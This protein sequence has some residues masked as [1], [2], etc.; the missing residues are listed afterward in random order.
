MGN[1]MRITVI[2]GLLVAGLDPT[3]A[4]QAQ[5]AAVSGGW[6]AVS[7][8]PDGIAAA[9]SAV[10][11]NRFWLELQDSRLTVIRPIRNTAVR[12]EHVIGGAEVRSIVPGAPCLGD[13][14]IISSV[15]REGDAFVHTTVAMIAAGGEATTRS[16]VRHILRP[17]GG[18]RLVVESTMR[19]PGANAPTAVA[20]VYRRTTDTLPPA[21][22]RVGG[23][24]AG[25]AQVAWL[26][27]AWSGT[28]GTSA[29][30][31]R[32][33]AASGGAMFATSRT[34]RNSAV[35]EFEFLCIAE[36]DGSLVYSAM[37][38][39]RAPAVDFTLT[40]VDATS[41]T[42][43]NPA[44]DFP[45]KIRYALKPDGAL[46]ATISGAPGQRSTTFV[47][48]RSGLRGLL[49]SRPPASASESGG[50]RSPWS[51]DRSC[52]RSPSP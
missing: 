45:K 11:G 6:V 32:W 29:I 7:D 26:S 44:H 30:E 37:P 27:G 31:E 36:R 51:A 40:A 42:F 22:T 9:P 52:P 4:R 33:T 13:S 12:A 16:G 23:V 25:L 3:S 14:A 46:E 1:L 21:P 49:N 28:A 24:P 34:V 17:A 20:T 8:A 50:P 2:A 39:G 35:A 47:F 38:N 41:A 43:E 18:D 48:T 15:S 5:P 19:T 10:F